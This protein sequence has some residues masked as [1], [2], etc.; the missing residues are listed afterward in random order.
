MT[1]SNG[2]GPLVA[3]AAVAAAA[4]AAAAPFAPGLAAQ[5]LGMGARQQS[6]TFDDP[7]VAGVESVR[8]VTV[9]FAASTPLGSRIDLSVG[10]VWAS[11]TATGAGG[12]EV[13]L[14][15]PTDT[16]VTLSVRPGPDWLAASVG[17]ALPTG[18]STLDTQES[19]VASLVAAELLP[20]S[21]DTWGSGGSFAGDVAAATQL[22]AWGAGLSVGYR[23][24]HAYEPVPDLP[25][26]YRPGSELRVSLA[27]D[28]DVSTSGTFSV[29]LGVQEYGDD[30][31]AEQNLFR[32]GTR[33]QG[34][35]SYAFA[36]GLRS[37]AMVYGGINHRAHG[38]VLVD[39]PLLAGATD[40]PSQQLFMG[41]VD[42]RVPLGRGVAVFP[43]VEGT[44]FRASDGASQGWLTTAGSTFDIRLAGNATTRQL[45]LSPTALARFGRVVVEDGVETGFDGWELG[46]SLRM[47][48]GR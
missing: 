41:G 36:V 6:Y 2:L 8:L 13:S 29:L 48:P 14:S 24:A 11:A 26:T 1:G 7:G 46:L 27:F 23:S 32:S 43:K 28:R 20:F 9:P 25:F 40:S 47:V 5:T 18:E 22:G 45:V 39:D 15:G 10:G 19:L 38:T 37:S 21:I 44:V 3:A 16:D 33:I 31:I 35:V 30:E 4:V 17:V 42:V 12:Q 34:L